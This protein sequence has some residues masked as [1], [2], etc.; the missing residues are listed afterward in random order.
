MLQQCATVCADLVGSQPRSK[1]GNQ[2]LLTLQ[3]ALRER[4]FARFGVPKV[5]IRD[6]GVQFASRAFKKFLGDMGIEQQFTAPYTPLE[7]PTER[8]NRTV[9]T[10][11]SKLPGKTRET[12]TI[13][14]QR[15]CWLST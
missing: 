2:M 6:S 5:L 4:I 13:G 15:L 12:E 11:I 7:Y 10:M 1:H 8:A 3:K 9:K 14:G